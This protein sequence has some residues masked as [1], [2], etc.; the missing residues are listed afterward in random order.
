MGGA[1]GDGSGIAAVDAELA[2]SANDLPAVAS[3]A[4]ATGSIALVVF[5]AAERRLGLPA[6]D[7]DRVFAAIE[8]APLVGAPEVIAGVINVHGSVLPVLDLRRR[9]GRG[10]SP[11]NLGA[12]LVVAQGAR[13]SIA[14]LADALDGV[15][16]VP[17]QAIAACSVLVPGASLLKGVAAVPDGLILIQDVEAF[18][19][20]DEEASL[21]AA[22]LRA[23]S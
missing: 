11:P 9:L 10:Q 4:E 2:V 14:L 18:L 6:V 12:K 3:T 20:A 23:E 8:I 5:H 22:L 15:R 13:R 7:V 17:L 19:S 16:E 1:R 21:D